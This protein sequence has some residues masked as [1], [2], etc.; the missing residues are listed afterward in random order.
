MIQW[1]IDVFGAGRISMLYADREFPPY[2]F[3]DFLINDNRHCHKYLELAFPEKFITAITPYQTGNLPFQIPADAINNIVT[4]NTDLAIVDTTT[5]LFL[6][7]RLQT[8]KHTVYPLTFDNQ[9]KK[10]RLQLH[11]RFANFKIGVAVLTTFLTTLFKGFTHNPTINFVARCK[12]S[13]LVSDGAKEITL[14]ELYHDLHL[15]QSKTVI[16]TTIRRAFGS[17]LYISA[18]KNSSL[19]PILSWMTRLL[20]TKSAGILSL[21]SVSL[22]HWAS[23]LK[24]VI[25]PNIPDYRYSC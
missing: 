5:Q 7:Q 12:S 6:V 23:I 22:S 21:C 8:T 18:R 25:L 19:F 10:V 17:Q 16:T 14:A 3:L 4:D 15:K 24:Q 1:V 2:Q 20:S 11:S 13:T 9:Y